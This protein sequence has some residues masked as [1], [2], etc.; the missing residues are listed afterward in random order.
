MAERSWPELG[1]ELSRKALETVEQAL[2]AHL[3]EGDM[4]DR[5]LRLVVDAVCD[6]IQGLVPPK[7]F[8]VIYA[9]RKELGLD[10]SR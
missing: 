7:A 2:H 5:E 4:T 3:V 8:D 1:E 10:K 6:T 9:I